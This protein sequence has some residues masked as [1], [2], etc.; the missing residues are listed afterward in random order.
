MRTNMPRHEFSTRPGDT[1]CKECNCTAAEHATLEFMD[2][3][4]VADYVASH[5]V[6]DVNPDGITLA[7]ALWAQGDD[8]ATIGHE[9]V[10]R[11]LI[12]G[13]PDGDHPNG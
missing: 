13:E 10:F 5:G 3:T 2:E 11:G 9:I 12:T 8:Y 1:W 4:D 6:G 7:Y